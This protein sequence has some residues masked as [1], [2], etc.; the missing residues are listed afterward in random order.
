MRLIVIFLILFS[1]W[2][3][4]VPLAHCET[5][6][7]ETQPQTTATETSKTG[8]GSRFVKEGLSAMVQEAG[9]VN[10]LDTVTRTAQEAARSVGRS[11][12]QYVRGQYLQIKNTD[13]LTRFDNALAETMAGLPLNSEERT[14]MIYDVQHAYIQDAEQ[15]K[16]QLDQTN[17]RDL[18]ILVRKSYSEIVLNRTRDGIIDTYDEKGFLKTRWTKQNGILDGPVITYYRNGEIHY[19]DVYEKGWKVN[20]KKYDEEGQLIFDQNYSYQKT[21]PQPE[22]VELPQEE[23]IQAPATANT[24][25]AVPQK[26]LQTAAAPLESLPKNET[27]RKIPVVFVDSASSSV[28]ARQ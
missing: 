25:P 11:L 1:L 12:G 14:Q 28:P 27:V 4:V 19:I 10:P 18:P 13:L 8:T 21:E 7:E 15:G 20:R 5:S 23:Q 16:Y 3:T 17:F 2:V 9:F 22:K 6:L 26:T 24:A